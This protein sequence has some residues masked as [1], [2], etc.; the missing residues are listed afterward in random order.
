M[1]QKFDFDKFKQQVESGKFRI[2]QDWLKSNQFEVLSPQNRSTK[3][4]KLGWTEIEKT[5]FSSKSI[6]ISTEQQEQI[7]LA[8]I[9]AVLGDDTK[10]WK[11]FAE[12]FDDKNSPVKKMTPI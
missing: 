7:T 4:E 8:I 9:K 10:T 3:F 11:S 1:S 12:M 2:L 5:V 6:K